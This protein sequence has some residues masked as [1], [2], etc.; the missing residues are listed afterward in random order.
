MVKQKGKKAKDEDCVGIEPTTICSAGKRSTAELTAQL[1]N[2][3]DAVIVDYFDHNS[4]SQLCVNNTT[5][6]TL[7][8]HSLFLHSYDCGAFVGAS[9][10]L[11]FTRDKIG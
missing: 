5:E 2:Q 7:F 11:L 1:Y 10:N 8:L 6:S 4:S 9:C 3:R